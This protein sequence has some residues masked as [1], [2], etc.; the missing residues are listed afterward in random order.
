MISGLHVTA[1]ARDD[2]ALPPLLALLRQDEDTL[3]AFLGDA[4]TT[5]LAKILASLFDGD[6]AP[7]FR[8]IL[9]S[10]VDDYARMALLAA[11]T[12]LTLEG[13][14]EGQAMRDLLVRFDEAKAAVEG[15][16]AWSGWEEAVAQLGLRELAPRVAAA[17]AD[18][19]IDPMFSGPDRF[20]ETL[21][22]AE[23]RPLDRSRL[24]S[25]QYGYLDD[26]VTALDWTVEG[27]GL[28]QKNPVKDVGRNDPC[29]CGSGKKFKKCCLGKVAAEAPWMPPADSGL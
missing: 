14:I 7:L 24:D 18:G 11:C 13:R 10:T 27:A 25:G 22:R 29:P 15:G 21:R 16:P 23:K 3:D 4:L 1:K 19:R 8:L 2:R 20:E 5:T 6:A 17:Q 9:D 26:P 28:P 12:F